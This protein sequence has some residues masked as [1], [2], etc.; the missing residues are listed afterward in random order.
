MVES[1]ITRHMV[2]KVYEIHEIN[3]IKTGEGRER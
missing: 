3:F 1:L 2:L